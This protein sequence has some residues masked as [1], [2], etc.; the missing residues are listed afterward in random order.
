[1]KLR[2]TLAA[3][4]SAL[5]V[6]SLFLTLFVFNVHA[7]TGAFGYP[8]VGSSTISAS[9]SGADLMCG[10]HAAP[11]LNGNVTSINVFVYAQSGNVH[12]EAALY[13]Y[14]GPGDAG[15]LIA[16][17]SE[18]TVGTTPTWQ[19][20]TFPTHP[21]VTAGTQ[22]WLVWW[23]DAPTYYR[24]DMDGPSG[25]GFYETR[26]PFGTWP[27]PLTGETSS[28]AKRSIYATYNYTT[29][30]PPDTTPPAFSNFAVSQTA[31][32]KSTVLAVDVSDT[33]FGLSKYCFCTNNTGAFVNSTF[34]LFGSNPQTV[35]CSLTLNSSVGKVIAWRIY[36]NDTSDNWAASSLQYLTTTMPPTPVKTVIFSDGFESGTLL[37]S[38][39]P[40]GAWDG[41]YLPDGAPGGSSSVQSKIVYAGKFAANFTAQNVTQYGCVYKNLSTSYASLYSSAEVQLTRIPLFA[42]LAPTLCNDFDHGTFF[43]ELKN[44]SGDRYWGIEIYLDSGW[45]D[46]WESVPSDPSPGTWYNVTLFGQTGAGTGA[47]TLWVNGVMK[48]SVTGQSITTRA[49]LTC[50]RDE[51]WLDTSES[52][53]ISCYTDNIVVYNYTMFVGSPHLL[54]TVQP[55]QATYSGGQP[56]IFTVDVL[57]QLCPALASTLTLT[58]TGPTGYYYFDYQGVSVTANSV[59]EYGFIWTTPSVT[60]TYMVEVGLMP[61]Q[62]T[63]YDAVWLVVS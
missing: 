6:I 46:V 15:N 24:Y 7:T 10:F 63:A 33:D 58:V 57:N 26:S 29:P 50:A 30:L 11:S 41:D 47:A 27:S 3:F 13:A 40:P 38:Q 17:T 32:G 37:K 59:D 21:N 61:A 34:A 18:I 35:T 19:T 43:T 45:A 23:Q 28:Y 39:N 14:V 51:F 9:G 55:G 44:V 53:P 5:L 42:V 2:D 36:A 62:L 12:L 56:V 52:S 54:L 22:Y 49:P 48:V 60:G 4:F 8:I 1:M 25:C 20:L 31:A 16:N